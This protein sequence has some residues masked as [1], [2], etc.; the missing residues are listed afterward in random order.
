MTTETK[1]K[2]V[3]RGIIITLIVAVLLLAANTAHKIYSRTVDPLLVEGSVWVCENPEIYL[4]VGIDSDGH[5]EIRGHII[6]NGEAK[7]ASLWGGS[8]GGCSLGIDGGDELF[9]SI[10]GDWRRSKEG[11]TIDINSNHHYY[12]IAGEFFNYSTFEFKRA[13]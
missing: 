8:G 6:I 9:C 13:E 5:K 7:P 11:F 10:D 12:E 4:E 2:T 1:S 3:R